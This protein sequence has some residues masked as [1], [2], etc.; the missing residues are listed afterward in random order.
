[1]P[2]KMEDKSTDDKIKRF[3]KN[4]PVTPCLRKREPM[5]C[6]VCKERNWEVAQY[7]PHVA[8]ELY[9]AASIPKE[10][11]AK[12]PG[13]EEVVKFKP[14]PQSKP[15]KSKKSVFKRKEKRKP[16]VLPE[17]RY[18]PKL[19]EGFFTKKFK[20][21]AGII[22][23]IA[24]IL[25]SISL[26]S[27]SGAEDIQAPDEDYV[28][29]SALN[30]T[31]N[32]ISIK[33][34]DESI[35]EEIKGIHDSVDWHTT[36]VSKE[37]VRYNITDTTFKAPPDP[38]IIDRIEELNLKGILDFRYYILTSYSGFEATAH[39]VAYGETGNEAINQVIFNIG[40]FFE[41]LPSKWYQVDA[42]GNGADME[43]ALGLKGS[44]SQ[45]GKIHGIGALRIDITRKNELS[46]SLD[47]Y[48]VKPFSYEDKTYIWIIGFRFHSL[49]GSFCFEAESQ[50]IN[51]D[52]GSTQVNVE[53]PY[54]VNWRM[55]EE[56]EDFEIKMGFAR[57][58]VLP[59]P[60]TGVLSQNTFKTEE[61]IEPIYWEE[62][63]IDD[64]DS[65]TEGSLTFW[66]DT[67][68]SDFTGWEEG[69]YDVH[70]SWTE[71]TTKD[72]EDNE[73]TYQVNILDDE[74]KLEE[75]ENYGRFV[76]KSFDTGSY[77]EYNG[78]TTTDNFEKKKGILEYEVWIKVSGDNKSWSK[79]YIREDNRFLRGEFF[80]YKLVLRYRG[81]V[82]WDT[83]IIYDITLH[84][85][86]LSGSS[87]INT[88]GGEIKLKQ[89]TIGNV[90]NDDP[91]FNWKFYYPCGV[92]ISKPHYEG[93]LVYIKDVDANISTPDLTQLFIQIGVSEDNVFSLGEWYPADSTVLGSVEGRYFK[94][95]LE[96]ITAK[97]KDHTPYLYDINITF[98]SNGTRSGRVN[99][100]DTEIKLDSFTVHFGDTNLNY[101]Y[102]EGFFISKE[103]NIGSEVYLKDVNIN[104]D[105]QP[106]KTDIRLLISVDGGR[107]I[108]NGSTDWL[109]LHGT[110]FKYKLILT[111]TDLT[112]T[113]RIYSVNISF[114]N[115]SRRINVSENEVK[116]ASRKVQID[117]VSTEYYY[118]S[119]E[120][121][122]SKTFDAG[123]IVNWDYLDPDVDMDETL[124]SRVEIYTQT[125]W[126]N[127]TWTKWVKSWSSG[128]I[129]NV[130]MPENGRYLQYK[131]RFED[132]GI[133]GVLT[134]TPKFHG[135]SI[136]YSIPQINLLEK[137]WFNATFTPGLKEAKLNYNEDGDQQNVEW[138][139]TR[140]SNLSATY[141]EEGLY[142]EIK[143]DSMPKTLTLSIQKMGDYSSIEYSASNS[144]SKISFEE[145]NLN[146]GQVAYLKIRDLP[147]SVDL[148]GAF[149]IPPESEVEPEPSETLLGLILNRAMARVTAKLYR[150]S[151]TLRS[152]PNTMLTPNTM[153]KLDA[154]EYMDIEFG[155]IY[156][157]Y[158]PP[159]ADSI[160]MLKNSIE[161]NTSIV[162]N[163]TQVKKIHLTSLTNISIEMERKNEGELKLLSIA[164]K[165]S[166][167]TFSNLPKNTA[168][169][170][171][172]DE[173]NLYGN[174]NTPIDLEVFIATNLSLCGE[175]N[176]DFI[177]L[178][179]SNNSVSLR[180]SNI[181]SIFAGN[182][183][184]L[185][186]APQNSLKF[187]FSTT[188]LNGEALI[189]PLPT[190]FTFSLDDTFLPA[191]EIG[192]IS[193]QKIPETL[194]D[195]VESL[196]S[197]MQNLTNGFTFLEKF[198][199]SFNF[200]DNITLLINVSSGDCP[201]IN[202]APGIV[203]RK[204]GKSINGKVY[205]SLP[206]EGEI[207]TNLTE[208]R[209][210]AHLKFVQ[211]YPN[212][213]WLLINITGDNEALI[214]M[215]N[216]TAQKINATID[217]MPNLALPE[218]HQ[219]IDFSA[220]NDLGNFYFR[221]KKEDS[222][223]EMF[224]SEIPLQITASSV[225]SNNSIIINYTST[226]TVDYSFLN[227]TKECDGL[228]NMN[229]LIQEIPKTV[230]LKIERDIHIDP[231]KLSFG[232]MLP[233][234]NMSADSP[235]EIH[236]FLKRPETL[237]ILQ[238]AEEITIE[239]S[240]DQ[241]FFALRDCSL[242]EDYKINELK[243]Y[244]ENIN[245]VYVKFHFLFGKVPITELKSDGTVRVNIDYE[246]EVAGGGIKRSM[247]L[248]NMAL[249]SLKI[250]EN[251]I[252]VS[253]S[254]T[255]Y[256]IPAPM[257]SL[258]NWWI[259]IVA[260]VGIMGA[261]S[262]LL[263]K[264]IRQNK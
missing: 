141:T 178:D 87:R 53:P 195:M 60:P 233:T 163:I 139:G 112:T 40:E 216:I 165:Q 71:S 88:T 11:P 54:N 116:L 48:F 149:E 24:I 252:A 228:R 177:L 101:H 99:V 196:I 247:V 261:W 75:G 39:G 253:D 79:W 91:I 38:R 44:L 168:L 169:D 72:F 236:I 148:Y 221:A 127:E 104:A 10:I 194:S 256:I 2:R 57:V 50:N 59:S 74:I 183:I 240:V 108:P 105:T 103:K 220:S 30:N 222:T 264:R 107:W 110:R 46:D 77:V 12:K 62:S 29:G 161:T 33:L 68:T 189:E 262:I 36:P 186:I 215:E 224:L 226:K 188:N 197:A 81:L 8:S 84:F 172:K 199:L 55:S 259:G 152:I 94:Y 109:E 93:S 73:E 61:E 243:I 6:S 225:I 49:P 160:T 4:F 151:E 202:W 145:H 111:T 249:F 245:T 20:V 176:K 154:P 204:Q 129:A 241:L 208:E 113:P 136:H 212:Y 159:E 25:Q 132:I 115:I 96:L 205:L 135:I 114:Q 254:N 184:G 173:G 18:V 106:P 119:G 7:C 85:T 157:R 52:I 80:K 131:V 3:L 175:M 179:Q 124:G 146:I 227:L 126:D 65:A 1:M 185:N 35:R 23:V 191:R 5:F 237:S 19:E 15:V 198:N 31:K 86:D 209:I 17:K 34:S 248:C 9:R 142:A 90:D 162:A 82:G 51:A 100:S 219:Y 193:I 125:S 239:G 97:P 230:N 174:F 134:D 229:V 28:M 167:I 56:I 32:D 13:E 123:G 64:W 42:N 155:I 187:K 78:V 171:T 211:Y 95:R 121:I 238:R 27:M 255:H 201:E 192:N 206:K 47:I 102:P 128:P 166:L 67:N 144:I 98:G 217:V 242:S 246:F 16:K 37:K 181:S 170:L 26:L 118:S 223:I 232:K 251:S 89:F 158:I 83:P 180:L 164:E 137:Y 70:T 260:L 41:I 138:E 58:E 182:R 213:D 130:K 117:G 133:V 122:S 120:F 218:L 14:V 69:D 257:L 200:S 153:F 92:F 235:A 147:A 143:V 45:D 76:S 263:Y 22:I 250:Q 156:G 190:N 231:E 150:V 210:Y 63:N 207:S 21:V 234:I 244:A 66:Y 203:A 140:E 43:V 258:G 214:Y